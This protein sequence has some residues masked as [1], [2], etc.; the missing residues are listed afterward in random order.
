MNPFETAEDP[1][2]SQ[3]SQ[4]R[5]KAQLAESLFKDTDDSATPFADHS[6]AA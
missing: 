4:K 3:H 6:R 1:F 5:D 2:S